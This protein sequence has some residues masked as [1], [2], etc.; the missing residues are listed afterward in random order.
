MISTPGFFCDNNCKD[1]VFIGFKIVDIIDYDNGNSL[2][3]YSSVPDKNGMIRSR[4]ISST[5]SLKHHLGE[6]PL[7]SFPNPKITF[8]KEFSEISF[9]YCSFRYLPQRILIFSLV[10][11]LFLLLDC[12]FHFSC[13]K[14][15]RTR[16]SFA[17]I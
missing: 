16:F 11:R 13:L 10:A 4:P 5:L 3:L 17:S 9:R 1:F 8:Q 12:F 6:S 7:P 14:P 15:V 2:A